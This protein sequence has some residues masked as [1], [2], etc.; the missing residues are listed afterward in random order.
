MT[1]PEQNHRPRRDLGELSY[2]ERIVDFE[3]STDRGPMSGKEVLVYAPGKTGTVS[4]YAGIQD[5]LVK[6]RG[7]SDAQ[8]KMLHNHSNRHLVGNLRIDGEGP[9]REALLDR[10]IIRDLADYKALTGAHLLVVSSYREPLS[11]AFSSVFQQLEDAVRLRRRNPGSLTLTDC[12]HLILEWLAGIMQG[13]AHPLTELDPAFFDTERFDRAQ[14][15]CFVERDHCRVLVLTL[16]HVDAWV[17]AFERCLGFDGIAFGHKNIAEEKVLG[18][19]YR[20]LKTDLR[21]SPELIRRLYYDSAE[22]DC[23][24]WFFSADEVDA[25]CDQALKLYGR[26]AKRRGLSGWLKPLRSRVRPS[27]V[28]RPNMHATILSLSCQLQRDDCTDRKRVL[29]KVRLQNTGRAIWS[30]AGWRGD[31]VSAALRAKATDGRVITSSWHPIPRPLAPNDELD[32]LLA[33]DIPADACDADWAFDLIQ[34]RE[35][36]LSGQNLVLGDRDCRPQSDRQSRGSRALAPQLIYLHIPKTAGRSVQDLLSTSYGPEAV[37]HWG[38]LGEYRDNYDPIRL[39]GI[40]D[41]PVVLGHEPRRSYPADIGALFAA[42]LRDPVARALS[43]FGYYVRP[44]WSVVEDKGGA[45][46]RERQRRI[47]CERGMRPE[48]I[49]RSIEDCPAFRASISNTQCRFLSYCEPSFDG[50]LQTMRREAFIVGCL[51]VRQRFLSAMGDLLGWPSEM[52]KSNHSKPG[53][54]QD[55]LADSGVREAIEALNQEDLK[56]LRFVCD[57]CDG[58]FVHLPDAE[59]FRG[60]RIDLG[61]LRAASGDARGRPESSAR[62]A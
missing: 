43:L 26:P 16:P 52:P 45:S 14:R 18:G 56:L 5:Y 42:L 47:W 29:V 1:H 2:L 59:R 38:A 6:A 21:L 50:A 24:R 20:Q 33:C 25:L 37:L 11:R 4:L 30:S 41:Y 39:A 7:W 55:L 17:P 35:R 54:Y 3:D 27:P 22:T 40:R 58:L 23:L 28:E 9:S 34:G 48:S 19:L 32:W 12:E 44:D 49:L 62:R 8:S 36:W 31:R 15:C 60:S 13:F 46:K 61:A 51:N 10:L 57:D 53:A